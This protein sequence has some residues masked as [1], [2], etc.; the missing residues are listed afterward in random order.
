MASLLTVEVQD[1]I[2]VVELQNPPV[3]ALTLTL[4][5]ELLRCFQEVSRDES[6]AAVL[7]TGDGRMFSAGADIHEFD[8]RDRWT[9]A[10]LAGVCACVE[11]CP[12]LVVMGLN[13]PALGGGLELA[14]SADYRVAQANVMLGLPE[15]QLGLIPGAGGTQRLPRRIDPRCAVELIASGQPVSAERALQWGLID[16]LIDGKVDF[17]DA[18]R[19]YVCELLQTRAPRRRCVDMTAPV[20]PREAV[21]QAR[22]RLSSAERR[23]PAREWSLQAVESAAGLELSAGL[24][25]EARLFRQCLETPE[26][27]ALRHVF[28][29]E[30][31]ARKIPGVER[32]PPARTVAEVGI[33]GS[34]TM[35][36]GIALAFLAAGFAV[37]ILELTEAALSLGLERIRNSLLTGVE[38]GRLTQDQVDQQLARLRGTLE[39]RD[40]ARVDLVIEA[41]FEDYALKEQVFERLDEVCRPGCI[42]ATNTS[43]LDVNR[44]AAH[45]SRP[46]DVIGMHF[47]S[48]AN[49]MRLL[50]IVRGAHTG[51]DVIST[52]Q[53][54]A[55]QIGKTPVVVGV[56]FGFVGNRMMEP[57]VREAQRLV[58]EGASPSHVDRVLTEFGMAMGPLAVLDLAGL[59]VTWRIRQSRRELIAHDASYARLGD[60]LYAL[61]RYG[62]KTGR[63]Y[64]RYEG[65][66]KKDDPE[67]MEL[68]LRLSK[69]LDIVQRS[70]S[71][72]EI[73]ER[74]LYSLI[75]EGARVLEEGIAY[76]SADCDVVYVEGYGFPRWRGGPMHYAGEIGLRSVLA[77]LER[78]RVELGR[79][80]AMWFEASQL[81]R[82]RAAA[83]AGFETPDRSRG[84]PI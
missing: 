6:V 36:A 15:V 55:R 5:A 60:E 43:T 4:R 56:G 53:Q 70:I 76:R 73:L 79:Y 18:A 67:V 64:Y 29:A 33:V 68:A 24:E 74:C 50:E 69:E 52:A 22:Q 47:F 57:Y 46:G 77:G 2:A 45:T 78:Y 82:E 84:I 20:L 41:V 26:H 11:A 38:R 65:R 58:L 8:V 23:V 21:E 66:Q 37:S 83:G 30:R 40:L 62:Q 34:G 39:Y 9:E 81:L 17:R 48:P 14:L 63:G 19:R 28:L 44:F 54:I 49:V 16:R 31:A 51:V 10:H 59:D 42:L 1:A 27:R 35:G 7:V 72:R 25:L 3:N 75:D 12:K 61:G 32:N 13:G 71:D 80:G